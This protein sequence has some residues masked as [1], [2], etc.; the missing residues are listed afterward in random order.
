MKHFENRFKMFYLK[1]FISSNFICI[2]IVSSN[3]G[4]CFHY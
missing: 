1:Y 4:Y 2:Q 3:L